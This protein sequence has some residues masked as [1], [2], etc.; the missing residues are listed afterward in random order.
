VIKEGYIYRPFIKGRKTRPIITMIPRLLLGTALKYN[1]YITTG[2]GFYGV[3]LASE[4][5]EV[6]NKLIIGLK[7]SVNILGLSYE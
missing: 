7:P 6:L 4:S 1:V 5:G 2:H 3:T